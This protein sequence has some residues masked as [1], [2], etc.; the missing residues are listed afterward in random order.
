MGW[1]GEVRKN[2]HASAITTKH[3]SSPRITRSVHLITLPPLI[4]VVDV[5]YLFVCKRE[6][7]ITVLLIL[8]LCAIGNYY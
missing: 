8:S 6:I 1:G 3:G 7:V 5:V 4:V 2:K